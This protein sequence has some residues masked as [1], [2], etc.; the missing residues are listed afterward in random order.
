MKRHW[1]EMTEQT[2]TR[3]PSRRSLM[4]TLY[5]SWAGRMTI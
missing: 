5:A 2:V 3:E 1:I 4:A